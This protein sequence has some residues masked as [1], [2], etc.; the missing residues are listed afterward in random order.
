MI[1]IEKH[2]ENKIIRYKEKSDSINEM[3][4]TIINRQLRNNCQSCSIIGNNENMMIKFFDKD[5]VY[6]LQK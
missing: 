2:I 3:A 4:K 5:I 1:Y 6:Y